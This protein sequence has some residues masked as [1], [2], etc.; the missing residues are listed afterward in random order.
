MIQTN[1]MGMI[2]LALLAFLMAV[3]AWGQQAT[4]RYKAVA[5]DFFV[6]FN[7]NSVVAEVEEVFPGKGSDFTR[8]WRAKLFE[9]C[10]L[11]SITGEHEDFFKLADDALHYTLD[12]Q[13][14]TATDEQKRQLLN[15]Y[16]TLAPW[17]DAAEGLRKLKASGV[18]IITLANFSTAMLRANVEKAGIADLFDELLSTD[19]NETFKPDPK[20]Y[21]LGMERLGLRKD[22]IVFAAFGGWDVYGAKTFGYPTYW[23]NRFDL[24]AEKLG[25]AADASSRDFQGLLDFVLGK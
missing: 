6:I 14:L 12:A 24:P 9:Y 7:P 11:R 8:A 10:F 22:E 23:V 17:P 19:V 4:P 20:A 3:P 2:V 5:F 1:K 16:V 25:T 13:K 15:A 18:R 21:A